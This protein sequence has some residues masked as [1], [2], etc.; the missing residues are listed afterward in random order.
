M[1]ESVEEARTA[2]EQVRQRRTDE[3]A[4]FGVTSV[5]EAIKLRDRY[6]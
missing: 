5:E 6:E 1:T 3:L 2:V 4:R